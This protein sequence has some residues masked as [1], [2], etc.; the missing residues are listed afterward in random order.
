MTALAMSKV[1][2][3]KKMRATRIENQSFHQPPYPQPIVITSFPT[4]TITRFHMP[5]ETCCLT[6]TV[7]IPS[8]VFM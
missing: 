7:F 5:L 2:F 1:D 8:L 4:N 3:V 6:V